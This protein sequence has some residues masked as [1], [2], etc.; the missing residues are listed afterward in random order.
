MDLARCVPSP[1]QCSRPRV[2]LTGARV[3]V[4]SACS[5]RAQTRPFPSPTWRCHSGAPPLESR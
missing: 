4:R 3:A 2:H 5:R 1:K